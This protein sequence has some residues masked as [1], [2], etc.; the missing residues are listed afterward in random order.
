MKTPKILLI[1]SA[2]NNTGVSLADAA[3]IPL[4][5]TVTKR[6]SFDTPRF[7]GGVFT[8]DRTGYYSLQASVAAEHVADLRVY[9]QRGADLYSAK[10]VAPLN[11]AGNADAVLHA[12]VSK[13]LFL[14]EGETVSAFFQQHG[15]VTATLWPYPDMVFFEAEYLGY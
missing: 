7:S 6:D 12:A 2:Q 9:L 3:S 10:S 14:N 1:E 11:S 13:R 8:A 15:S 5:P 4:N